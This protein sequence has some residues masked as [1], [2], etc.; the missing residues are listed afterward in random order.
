MS[1]TTAAAEKVYRALGPGAEI[2]VKLAVGA[3]ARL[4]WLPQETILFDRARLMRRIEVE[5][6]A[7][8][9]IVDGRGRGVRPLGDGRGGDGG[10][11]H[12]PLA[13]APRRPAG[14]CRDGAARRRDRA[15]ARRA[16]GRRRRRRHRNCARGAGR[17]G[18][19][20]TRPRANFLWR[21]RRLVLEWA[22]GGPSL[23]Q[24]WRQPAAR[25]RRCDHGAGR[26][27]CRGSG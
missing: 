18:D 13:G 9:H 19:G 14:V 2:A 21:G 6:A 16:G 23:R 27:R 1:V 22:C 17:S 3:G 4:S 26:L 24:G 20:R 5:L 15:D 8:C 7:G 11:V 10:R 12:R 25:S